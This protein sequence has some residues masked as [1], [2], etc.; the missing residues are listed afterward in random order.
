MRTFLLA[1]SAL[2]LSACSGPGVPRGV[3][4]PVA[5]PIVVD[6]AVPEEEAAPT[7]IAM[8][9][10]EKK[11]EWT[12]ATACSRDVP[13]GSCESCGG[14]WDVGAAGLGDCA[15]PMEHAGEVCR[16]STDCPCEVDYVVGVK[17]HDTV[18][19]DTHCVGPAASS[20]IPLGRCQSYWRTFGCWSWIEPPDPAHGN[21]RTFVWNCTD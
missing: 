21:M 16:D 18:C 4:T 12:C 15:C 9:A 17:F 13:E 11:V 8:P 20:G 6:A 19:D 2:T 7:F 1:A 3:A 5:A 10:L 14:K